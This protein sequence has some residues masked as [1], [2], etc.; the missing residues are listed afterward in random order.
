MDH[1]C[2]QQL[3]KL[4][5]IVLE[6]LLG[7]KDLL[8][9]NVQ[10]NG[11][12]AYLNLKFGPVGHVEPATPSPGF[13]RKS[14]CEKARD[15]RRQSAYTQER[16]YNKIKRQNYNFIDS[17]ESHLSEKTS[18]EQVRPCLDLGHAR[19]T[20][21][22]GSAPCQDVV[23]CNNN[24]SDLIESQSICETADS[25]DIS[26]STLVDK[27]N[28]IH[29][30]FNSVVVDKESELLGAMTCDNRIVMY[31]YS[32]PK[33]LP[34]TQ[35]IELITC[36]S[37]KYDKNMDSIRDMEN[38]LEDQKILENILEGQTML[39]HLYEMYSLLTEYD[40]KQTMNVITV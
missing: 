21:M 27:A 1:S 15:F 24:N 36:S 32:K 17:S 31:A 8:S 39:E 18:L 30:T 9:Y 7:E 14:P 26:T 25:H 38:I 20:L 40:T 11:E 16:D 23:P 2:V 28:T 6:Q 3:P 35:R 33:D 4:V 22:S 29:E 19:S 12:V 5:L 13:R 34:L 10:V 37:N